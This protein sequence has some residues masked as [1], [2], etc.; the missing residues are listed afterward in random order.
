MQLLGNLF[1]YVLD[2]RGESIN[3]RRHLPATPAPPPNTPCA[4][5]QRQ[6]LHALAGGQD[7]RQQ[8]QMYSLPD[9]NIFNV[10]V[11]GMFDDAQDIVKAVSN[12]ANFK[13]RYKIGAVNSI[14]WA[15]VAAQ[16]VYYFQGYFPGHPVQRRASGLRR[17]SG[18]FWQYLRRP[19]AGPS[20][21]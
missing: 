20:P 21:G 7:E 9:G 4:Q 6:G 12:D 10:A 17:P 2:K 8:A 18:N 11:T 3:I 15:R 1:E 5:A 14:N 19:A 16:I 13:A